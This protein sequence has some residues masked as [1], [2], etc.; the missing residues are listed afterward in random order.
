[1]GRYIGTTELRTYLSTDDSLGT[2]ENGLLDA[3][4]NRA[5]S[6]IDTYTRRSFATVQGTH[7]FSRHIAK[8]APGQALYL[9]DDLFALGSVV[10]ANGQ[11]IPNGSVW[12]EPRNE[13]PPYRIVRL[14]SSYVWTFNTDTEIEVSGGWGFSG[15]APNDIKQAAI[16]YA[17]YLYRQKDTGP[18][19]V[20]GFPEGG[21]VQ[22]KQGMPADVR[23]LIN[24]YR[25]KTGGVV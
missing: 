25:S 7:Y 23:Y 12:L 22:V 9:D 6:A 14:K 10:N 5:E 4:I 21:Q 8:I 18:G 11:H 3:C 15:T 16:R 1:M 17:A 20:A 2:Q 24:P 19:D 13:G